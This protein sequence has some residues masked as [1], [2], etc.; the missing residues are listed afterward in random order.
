LEFAKKILKENEK[1][2]KANLNKTQ[3]SSAENNTDEDNEDT[4]D[5]FISFCPKKLHQKIENLKMMKIIF[6]NNFLKGN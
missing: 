4:N 2:N 6:Y 1:R 3:N 5:N